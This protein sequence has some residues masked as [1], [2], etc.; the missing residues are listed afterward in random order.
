[1]LS[2]GEE[3]KLLEN[4]DQL[5][6]LYIKNISKSILPH[7]MKDFLWY[8][9]ITDETLPFVTKNLPNLQNLSIELN[10]VTDKGLE[11]LAECNQLKVLDA[12][13]RERVNLDC[14]KE[15]KNLSSLTIHDG[16][17][18]EDDDFQFL[19]SLTQ[20]NKLSLNRC[21]QISD[22]VISKLK[23]PFIKTLVFNSCALESEFSCNVV[24]DNKY[25]A[26]SLVVLSFRN[27][28]VNN[29]SLK[30]LVNLPCLH[31][32]ILENSQKCIVGRCTLDT[33]LPLIEI[34]TLRKLVLFQSSNLTE[35]EIQT[36]REAM[37]HLETFTIT[38]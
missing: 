23:S 29:K 4:L 15:L 10:A 18:Y 21:Y 2:T 19:E 14:F 5:E 7:S 16:N 36:L 8:R 28:N 30:S 27:C 17:L 3:I 11:T 33:L 6:S 35:E 1:V 13:C 37:A 34:P 20:L 25:L 31:T 32:L 24:K 9:P 26:S 12:T 22:A 38:Q